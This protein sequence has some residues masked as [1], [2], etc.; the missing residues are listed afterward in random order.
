MFSVPLVP[1]CLVF[2]RKPSLAVGVAKAASIRGDED[3]LGFGSSVEFLRPDGFL[4]ARVKVSGLGLGASGGGC[5][6]SFGVCGF[7]DHNFGLSRVFVPVSAFML[8]V[9]GLRFG[10]W[11]VAIRACIS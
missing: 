11:G 2:E 3:F 4:L 6:C 10:V 8:W 9:C 1:C 5:N 7:G